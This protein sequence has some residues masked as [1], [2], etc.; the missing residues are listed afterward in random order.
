MKIPQ[1]KYQPPFREKTLISGRSFRTF[2]TKNGIHLWE[3]DLELLWKK[4]LLI[5]SIKFFLDGFPVRKIYMEKNGKKAWYIINPEDLEKFEY[6]KLNPQVYYQQGSIYLNQEKKGGPYKKGFKKTIHSFPSQDKEHEFKLDKITHGCL[7][8]PKPFQENYRV[9][10]DKTQIIALKIILSRCGNYHT[11]LNTRVLE[12]PNLI[13]NIQK[14]IQEQQKFL[15]VFQDWRNLL[16]FFQ[17]S[18]QQK[19]DEAWEFYPKD[20]QEREKEYKG[21][22]DCEVVKQKPLFE[23]I[24]S[25]H[26]VAK[27]EMIHWR[28]FLINKSFFN[29]YSFHFPFLKKYLREIK[30][31]TLKDNE[32]I[33]EMV[34][35]LSWALEIITGK[36]QTLSETLQRMDGYKLCEI[37]KVM[38]KPR[39]YKQVTCGREPC[40]ILHKKRLKQVNNY[41]RK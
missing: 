32:Y 14:E 33:N 22:Y 19:S 7:T 18:C 15:R 20:K 12:N 34:D 30:N 41:Y 3:S 40:K 4:Q 8:S 17:K 21:F 9:Y 6:E 13:Q 25:K 26:K 10:F 2:C 11:R 37:C 23:E 27:D 5:P 24:L 31:R 39:N 29:E 16:D 28:D 38:F 1:N 35:D 36:E